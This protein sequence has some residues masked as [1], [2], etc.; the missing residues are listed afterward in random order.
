MPS[1]DLLES[2]KDQK[3]ERLKKMQSFFIL[4]SSNK[5]HN[6]STLNH[7]FRQPEEVINIFNITHIDDL[8]WA[9]ENDQTP[10]IDRTGYY[11]LS[12]WFV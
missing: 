4:K 11:N 9:G 5:V 7:I 8:V 6:I 1:P 3:T 12:W 10:F 2:W